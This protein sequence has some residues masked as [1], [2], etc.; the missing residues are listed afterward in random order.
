MADKKYTKL[1]VIH[2][3]PV[4]KN[5]FDTTVEQLF[6]KAN[7]ESMSAYVGRREEDLLDA[8]D[9]YILQPT[10]DRDKFSLEPAVSSIDQITG[11]STN[12]MF[13]EDYI[14]VLK[15][16]GVNTLNQNSIFDTE[17]Y[18]FLPPISIDKFVNYQEYFW[19]P[20]GPTPVIVEGTDTNPINIEKDIVGKKSFTTPSGVELKSGMVVTFSGNYVIP[21]KLKNEKRFIVEGVGESIILHDKEQNFATVFSTE[22]YIP[23]DQ[24]IIDSDD[25]LVATVP[26]GTTEFNSGGL[27]GVENYVSTAGQNNWP[28]PDYAFDQTD[29]D[30]G[31]ALW[32]GYVAPLGTQLVFTVGGEGAFDIEPF[33]SDNTQENPDYIIMERGATDNN[34]WSRINFW[35]HKNN[36]LD[37]GDQLPPKGKRAVRPIIEFDRNI[38][39][40]N[41]GTTGKFSVDMSAEGY[42]Q[43]E[44]VGRP[45]G[46]S[47]DSVTLQPG[48]TILLASD[49]ASVSQHAYIIN[50][51]GAGN[52]ALSKLADESSPAGLLDGDAGFIPY[53]AQKGDVITIKFGAIYEGIEYWL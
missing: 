44:V 40:Y 39:L 12:I 31:I 42:L 48:N 1:P 47:I 18:T 28:T 4:I 34:V 27:A 11:K 30:T 22:D 7:V 51:D 3:T 2:Q 50:D 45:T 25:D 43:S 29:P 19:S 24:T 8:R 33:D 21:N 13:Y 52:V 53:V 10:A 20:N 49:D 41:F 14:N 46:A 5:F 36:F 26:G 32:A 6:S 16:Y 35:H 23:F 9:T 37:V 38:E 15:S 17:A